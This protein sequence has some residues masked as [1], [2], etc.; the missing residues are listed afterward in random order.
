MISVRHWSITYGCFIQLRCYGLGSWQ[1]S[2]PQARSLSSPRW[3]APPEKQALQCRTVMA[4]GFLSSSPLS[5]AAL[6]VWGS[7]WNLSLHRVFRTE[8]TQQLKPWRWQKH[9][10]RSLAGRDPLNNCAWVLHDPVI[11]LVLFSH[12]I[13]PKSKSVIASWRPIYSLPTIP[14]CLLSPRPASSSKAAPLLFPRACLAP[15]PASSSG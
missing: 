10:A 9:K 4:V 15:P 2:S 7:D 12:L 14:M 5:P 1:S 3:P 8:Q 6:W 13:S 11:F